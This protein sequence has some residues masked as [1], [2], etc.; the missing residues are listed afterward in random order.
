ML[1]DS[2]ANLLAMHALTGCDTV[3]YPFGKGKV[4]AIKILGAVC[5]FVVFIDMTSH[6]SMKKL[7]RLSGSAITQLSSFYPWTSFSIG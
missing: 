7:L 3:S 4:N 1:G 2:C 6:L 5:L